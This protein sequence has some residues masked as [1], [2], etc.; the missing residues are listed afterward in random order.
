[1]ANPWRHNL[2]GVHKKWSVRRRVSDRASANGKPPPS[3][4]TKDPDSGPLSWIPHMGKRPTLLPGG[5]PS[6]PAVAGT[7]SSSVAHPPRTTKAGRPKGTPEPLRRGPGAPTLSS[8]GR[9]SARPFRPLPLDVSVGVVA[10]AASRRAAGGV[11]CI[12]VEGLRARGGKRKSVRVGCKVRGCRCGWGGGRVRGGARQKRGG[13]GRSVWGGRCG[14]KEGRG[15]G[16]APLRAPVDGRAGPESWKQGRQYPLSRLLD[17]P[18]PEKLPGET[19]GL[20]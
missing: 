12:A 4:K 7:C 20:G 6:A 13:A 18:T 2:L 16:G 3:V 1:M 19:T 10:A 15:R 5:F 9:R 17:L 8:A 11:V 14:R